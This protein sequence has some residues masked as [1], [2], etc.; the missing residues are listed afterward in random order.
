MLDKDVEKLEI[1]YRLFSN[2][3]KLTCSFCTISPPWTISKL[4]L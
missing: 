2:F 4:H 1:V 3:R